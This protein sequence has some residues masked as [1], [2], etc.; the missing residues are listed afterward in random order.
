MIYRSKRENGS[1]HGPFG[2]GKST[3]LNMI[4]LVGP[5]RQSEAITEGKGGEPPYGGEWAE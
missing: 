4:G 5:A 1:Y 3:L 2:S